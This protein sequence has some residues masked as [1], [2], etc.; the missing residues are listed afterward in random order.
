[1]RDAAAPRAC[2]AARCASSAC[3][4]TTRCPAAASPTGDWKARCATTP[5]A[6]RWRPSWPRSAATTCSWRRW[7][8]ASARCSASGS[9]WS[10]KRRPRARALIPRRANDIQLGVGRLAD[11]EVARLVAQALQV[12]DVLGPLHHPHQH[13]ADVA[14]AR[15]V[16]Q[17]IGLAHLLGRLLADEEVAGAAHHLQE[18]VV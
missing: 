16:L 6:A 15:P 10:A 1:S 3:A 13:L 11:R 7:A 14:V 4:T 5:T 2:C 12:G 8:C 17:Q 18:P 9:C